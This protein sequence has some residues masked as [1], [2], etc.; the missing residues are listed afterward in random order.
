MGT[1]LIA[2]LGQ[3][4]KYVGLAD[5]LADDFFCH[6]GPLGFFSRF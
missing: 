5:D 3:N 6:F 1:L 2:A 4:K